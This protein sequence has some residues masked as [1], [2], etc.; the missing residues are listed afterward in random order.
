MSSAAAD[1]IGIPSE[2]EQIRDLAV[3][4]RKTRLGFH[5]GVMHR[6]SE[7]ILRI[8][9][10]AF[11][12]KLRRE[13]PGEDYH[14]V[15]SVAIP[16]YRAE[17]I[18]EFCALVWKRAE[19]NR[20]PYAFNY[21]QAIFDRSTGRLRLGDREWGLTCATFVIALYKTM[22]FDLL[23]R[24]QWTA[25]ETDEQFM[26]MIVGELEKAGASREHVENVLSQTDCARFRPEEV[27]AGASI[28]PLPASFAL[29]GARA[30]V[31]ANLLSE[32]DSLGKTEERDSSSEQ[33]AE[34]GDE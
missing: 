25:R 23:Q 32:L 26:V 6:D 7:Q 16:Q 17:D 11:H 4:I 9:H 1:W 24:D 5:V 3:G 22:G 27:A 29:T 34:T 21:E 2:V 10:L 14:W 13:E 18:A 12:F 20:I 8:L 31:L 19:Q 15:H 28:D 30:E 33:S